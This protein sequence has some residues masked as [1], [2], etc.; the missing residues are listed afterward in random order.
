MQ[1]VQWIDHQGIL[2]KGG[3]RWGSTTIFPSKGECWQVGKQ[4]RTPCQGHHHSREN[5][6]ILSKEKLTPGQLVFSDQYVS[7]LPGTYHNHHGQTSAHYEFH[8][9]TLFYDAASGYIH[10]SNQVGFTAYETIEAKLRF[11]CKA[12][13]VGVQVEKYCTDNG[14]Y[15]SME[16]QR[17]L[18]QKGQTIQHSGIGGHHHNSPAENGIKIIIQKA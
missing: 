8:G 12:A 11:E 1:A 10:V 17:E 18:S 7:S 9:G 15:T 6:G 3:E 14:V 16:F 5:E 2:G 13:S 4:S